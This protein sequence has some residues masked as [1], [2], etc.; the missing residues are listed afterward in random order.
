MTL[1]GETFSVRRAVEACQTGHAFKELTSCKGQRSLHAMFRCFEVFLP[2]VRGRLSLIEELAFRFVERQAAQSVVYTEVESAL[3]RILSATLFF[4]LT[5]YTPF[6]LRLSLSMAWGHQVRYSPHLLA[7]GGLLVQPSS[8]TPESAQSPTQ[9]P[10]TPDEETAAVPARR[11]SHSRPVTCEPSLTRPPPLC[12][13]SGWLA[14]FALP[15]HLSH[16]L[17]QVS[18]EDVYEAVTRGLRRGEARFGVA[19][20][21][22]LCM[23]A[24]RP[25]WAVRALADRTGPKLRKNKKKSD[26][27][28]TLTKRAGSLLCSSNNPFLSL[29]SPLSAP[30][31]R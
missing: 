29:S 25:D 7:D 14:N 17:A 19:V 8:A 12:L 4:P 16:A 23:L 20:N 1:F 31:F 21:Q 3:P 13:S 9:I 15:L 18:A 11:G 10:T 24:F 26:K 2:V 28:N 6:F 22:I 5:P 30:I 27:K